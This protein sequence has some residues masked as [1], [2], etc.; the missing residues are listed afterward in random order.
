MEFRELEVLH[1]LVRISRKLILENHGGRQN[2][3]VGAERAD[4]VIEI[5]NGWKIFRGF[6]HDTEQ[7]GEGY[8]KIY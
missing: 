5:V 1:T 2:E 3:N 8:T 4:Q 6:Y 7:G